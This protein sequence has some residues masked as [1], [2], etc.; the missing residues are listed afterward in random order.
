M[1]NL[2]HFPVG[3]N[4]ESNHAITKR[5]PSLFVPGHSDPTGRVA[6]SLALTHPPLL[7]TTTSVGGRRA[8]AEA[9]LN[10]GD[11]ASG[12]DGCLPSFDQLEHHGNVT[13]ETSVLAFLNE[14]AVACC[15]AISISSSPLTE[16]GDPPLLWGGG[17]FDE[18]MEDADAPVLSCAAA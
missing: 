16:S 4:G 3:L 6:R 7:S 8:G 12:V 18:L 13:G 5:L 10:A 14:L 2:A 11:T 1:D 17:A 9:G 15:T